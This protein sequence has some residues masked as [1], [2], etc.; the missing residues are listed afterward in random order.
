LW[1]GLRRDWQNGAARR[2]PNYL[3]A[4]GGVA[5]PS[6][7]ANSADVVVE[8]SRNLLANAVNLGNDW[9]REHR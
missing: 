9:I 8:T 6:V 1:L 7:F 4:A 3:L 5:S 2:K